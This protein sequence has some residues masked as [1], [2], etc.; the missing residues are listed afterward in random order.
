MVKD[1]I[2]DPT[3][4]STL[5]VPNQFIRDKQ[6]KLYLQVDFNDPLPGN[7]LN[8]NGDP[9]VPGIQVYDDA[10]NLILLA[11]HTWASDNGEVL[12]EYDFTNQPAWEKIVFPSDEYLKINLVGNQGYNVLE[13]NIATECVPEP[14]TISLLALGALALVRRRRAR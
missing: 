13:W 9:D 5:L 3:S 4:P 1:P 6:K 14:A 10:G 2:W 7:P 12:L 8:P 11:D